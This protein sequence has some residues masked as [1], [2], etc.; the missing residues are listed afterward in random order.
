MLLLLQVFV[1]S[2]FIH[3]CCLTAGA[4]L[5]GHADHPAPVSAHSEHGGGA[6]GAD[7]HHGPDDQH[8]EHH[9]HDFGESDDSSD[10]C[11]GCAAGGCGFCCEIAGT[12]ALPTPP[13][14]ENLFA[15]PDPVVRATRTVQAELPSAPA[16]LLPP[17]NAPPGLL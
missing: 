1:L 3:A 16:F 15:A 8:D 2:G 6:V 5:V 9:H 11:G 14:A 4:S 10:A 13:V 7:H 12:P 17:A